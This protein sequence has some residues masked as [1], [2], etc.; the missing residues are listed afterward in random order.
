MPFGLSGAAP[1]FQKVIDLILK[2]VIRKFVSVYMDNVIPSPSFTQHVERLRE[3]FRL[4]QDAGLTLN[5]EKCKFSCDE[6]KYLGLIISKEG[7]KTDETKVRAIVEV[8]PPRN[9]KEV[10]K[11]LEILLVNRGAEGIRRGQGGDNESARF[12]IAGFQKAFRV[13]YGCHFNKFRRGSKS[14]AETSGICLSHA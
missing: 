13:V 11:F 5:K 12:K 14:G 10:S 6:L 4:L 9:S 3:V 8:K 7:I 1:N 2:P